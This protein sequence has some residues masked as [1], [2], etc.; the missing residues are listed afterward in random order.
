MNPAKVLLVDDHALFRHG[1]RAVLERDGDLQVVAEA[2]SNSEAMARAREL[3]PDLI[4]MDIGLTDGSSLEAIHAL[5][6]ELPD[7]K[8][9]VLTVHQEKESFFEAVKGG[10]DGFLSK[11]VRAGTLLES[12]RGVLRGEAVISGHMAANLCREYARL[13]QVEAGIVADQLTRREKQVLEKVSEGLSN[14]GIADRLQ[15]SEN[16]VRIHVSHILQKL[17]IHDR[18]Q[19]AAYARQMG[20]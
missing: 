20:L 18:S 2:E 15:I 12:L 10:A 9:V 13:A 19:A 3:H 16:T 5:K 17:H 11:D 6:R 14:K 8:I 4:L 1:V 7:A